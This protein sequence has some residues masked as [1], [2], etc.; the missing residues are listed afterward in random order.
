M[1]KITSFVLAVCFLIL[2][3]V[4]AQSNSRNLNQ[5]GPKTEKVDIQKYAQIYYVSQNT[6]IDK[7]G[8]GSK[9]S[10]FTTV[11]H[12]LSKVINNSEQYS[13]AVFV[14]EGVYSFIRRPKQLSFNYS[15]KPERA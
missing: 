5:L 14:A 1:K 15:K 8:D 3:S 11:T 7:K 12:A 6:G 2:S 13:V 4:Q 10:P 9:N